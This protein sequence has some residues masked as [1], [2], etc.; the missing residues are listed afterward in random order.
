MTRK[1]VLV[2][3]DEVEIQKL[4]KHF[5]EEDYEVISARTGAEALNL[6]NNDFNLQLVDIETPVMSGLEFLDEQR[7][8][9]IYVPYLVITGYT[10]DFP[11]YEG[12]I[13]RKPFSKKALK[14]KLLEYRGLT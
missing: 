6:I 1:K 3:E 8:R 9:G 2:L 13:L 14:K 7:K 4:I 10:Q 5:L 11:S 12:V